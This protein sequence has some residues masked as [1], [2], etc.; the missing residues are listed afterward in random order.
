ML[1]KA[2]L[3][4]G[5]VS[6]LLYVG[7][8]LLAAARYPGYHSFTSQAISELTALGAPTKRMVEPLLIGY[9]ILVIAFGVGVWASG[10][11]RILHLVGGL[12]VAI[13]VV[14]LTA[15]PFTP[16]HVRGTGTLTTDAP[17]IAA[18]AVIVLCILLA[19]GF[20]ASLFG[21]GFRLYSYA[22]LLTLLVFGTWTSLEAARLAAGQP[23]PWLGAAERVHIG[24]YLAWVMVLAV[25][26]WRTNT[27]R[28]EASPRGSAPVT[29]V[30]TWG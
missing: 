16:M 3:F 2:L 6:S 18:T 21:R 30:P 1:R 5:V 20:G 29:A 11:K 26:L 23:T 14:G 24:A 8:D 10:R 13:G 17:H 19:I 28:A 12:L 22:T 7:A 4:C 15:M 25:I 27:R 9:D